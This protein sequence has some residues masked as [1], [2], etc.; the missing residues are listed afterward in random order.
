MVET[1]R[2]LLGAFINIEMWIMLFLNVLV[3][4]CIIKSRLYA[5][6]DNAVYVLTGFNISCEICQIILHITYIG[7]AI[8]S[9]SWLFDGQDSLGVTVTA[10][11]FLGLWYLGSLMQIL[12][13]TNRLV[14][15]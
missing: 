2:L 11:I 9:G 1:V 13:A 10:V 4:T 3:L 7:P 5:K 15:I 14:Q 8:I 12:F 6:K